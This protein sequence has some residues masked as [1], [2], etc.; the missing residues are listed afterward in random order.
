MENPSKCEKGNNESD[1][2]NFFGHRCLKHECTGTLKFFDV[3]DKEISEENKPH[4]DS[5]K[6]PSD[7]EFYNCN[8]CHIVV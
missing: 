4:K 7:K 8:K 5:K 3:F 6:R 1:E 2:V